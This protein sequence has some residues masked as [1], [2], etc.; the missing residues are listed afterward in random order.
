MRMVYLHVYFLAAVVCTTG[1]EAEKYVSSDIKS[2]SLYDF[3]NWRLVRR[4][5][6]APIT[7][8]SDLEDGVCGVQLSG[9]RVSACGGATKVATPGTIQSNNRVD[10]LEEEDS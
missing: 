10:C 9:E 1:V 5:N 3:T 2:A 4:E 7:S 6:P 8:L